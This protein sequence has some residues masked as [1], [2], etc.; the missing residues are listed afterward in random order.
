MH[1]I[2][3]SRNVFSNK[4]IALSHMMRKPQVGSVPLNLTIPQ[5]CGITIGVTCT[6]SGPLKIDTK[7]GLNM[8]EMHL[9]HLSD[10]KLWGSKGVGANPQ[11]MMQVCGKERGNE[12]LDK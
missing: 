5:L 9:R 12:E 7:M 11:T 6:S 8:Q 10:K 1:V 4:G 2:I 3:H